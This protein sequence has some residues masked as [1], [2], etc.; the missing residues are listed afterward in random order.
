MCSCLPFSGNGNSGKRGYSGNR[1]GLPEHLRHS[2]PSQHE[3]A[4]RFPDTD[5]FRVAPGVALS[6][7][8]LGQFPC[9]A[10]AADGKRV[11]GFACEPAL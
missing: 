8:L 4:S 5:D 10:L 3:A 2:G 6:D 11:V 1:H 7:T 9:Q